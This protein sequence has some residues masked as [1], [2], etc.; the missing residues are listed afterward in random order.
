MTNEKQAKIDC[1]GLGEMIDQAKASD[2]WVHLGKAFSE[3]LQAMRCAVD[4]VIE[5]KE[6]KK[7]TKL[8]KVTV[9]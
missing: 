8:Q 6:Q 3:I 7:E 4:E 2:V 5:S 9:E 1:C